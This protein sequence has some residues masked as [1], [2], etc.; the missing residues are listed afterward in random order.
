MADI[1]VNTHMPSTVGDTTYRAI[2]VVQDVFTR[3]AFAEPMASQ[4]DAASA[5]A[6]VFRQAGR[7]G[8]R[9]PKLLVT[10]ADGVFQ[11]PAFRELMQ[12]HSVVHSFKESRNDIST[13]DRLISTIRRAL[14]EESAESG[15]ADWASRLRKVVAGYNQAP[16]SHLAGASPAEAGDGSSKALQFE[17]GRRAALDMAHNADEIQKRRAKLEAAGAFRVLL[18]VPNYGRRV[19]KNVWS[20]RV[21]ILKGFD[22]TQAHAVDEEGKSFPTKELLPVHAES[23]GTRLAAAQQ[24]PQNDKRRALLRRYADQVTRYLMPLPGKSA[25][26][27][28]VAVAL[29][30]GP[31]HWREATKLAGLNQKRQL[32]G[33]LGEFPELFEVKGPAVRLLV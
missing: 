25:A 6:A 12:Q 27:P 11:A 15:E 22:E 3:Y 19:Y 2:L 10:D 20:E 28:K 13:V 17:L 29:D 18:P 31:G 9:V 33:L 26:L 24:P 23:T 21:H 7:Q 5:M 32:A 16:H 1:I 4:V 8:H 14:A 30:R